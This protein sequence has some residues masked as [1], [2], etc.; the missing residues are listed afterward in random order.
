MKNMKKKKR[1]DDPPLLT[2]TKLSWHRSRASRAR[3]PQKKTDLIAF[4][5]FADASKTS[6]TLRLHDENKNIIRPLDDRRLTELFPYFHTG[7][8][9]EKKNGEPQTSTRVTVQKTNWLTFE[10]FT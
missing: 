2:R 8:G 3:A 10:S 4:V 7:G 5:P 6:S 9:G 1:I